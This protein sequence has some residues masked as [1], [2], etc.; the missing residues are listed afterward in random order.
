MLARTKGKSQ[1]QF[2]CLA[3]LK[4]EK[5]TVRIGPDIRDR[6]TMSPPVMEHTITDEVDPREVLNDL[7]TRYVTDAILGN[8]VYTTRIRDE[9]IVEMEAGRLRKR[10]ITT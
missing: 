8:S 2:P 7:T 4:I 9:M 1:R 3:L 6:P 10:A 5:L